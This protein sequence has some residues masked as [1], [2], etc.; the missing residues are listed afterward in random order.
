MHAGADRRDCGRQEGTYRLSGR[1]RESAQ[2]WHELLVEA[3]RRGLKI[4]SEIAVGALVFWKALDEVFP[5]TRHQ[6]CWVHKTANILNKVALSEQANMKKDLLE[7]TWR[8]TE[9]RRK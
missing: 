9:L 1:L 4:V 2:S 3:K 5:A 7:V 8:Q 6:R